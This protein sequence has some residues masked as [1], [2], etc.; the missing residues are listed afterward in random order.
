MTNIKI[1]VDG[2]GGDNAPEEIVKGAVEAVKSR[3]GFS[4]VLLG[5]AQAEES[6]KKYDYD[7]E[8]IEFV[9][10]EEVINMDDHPKEVMRKKH[11]SLVEGMMMVK[12]EQAQAFVSAGNTG[13]VLFGAQA[14][15]GSVDGARRARS[16]LAMFI[17]TLNGSTLLLDCG[18]NVDARA[19][20]LVRFARLGS[21]YYE[22]MKGVNRPKVAI[23]N[24]GSEDTK[25][26]ALVLETVPLLKE[27]ADINF[28][29][30][31][32]S[33]DIPEGKAD[34]VV[35]DAFV[36]NVILKLFEGVAT[37]M[38]KMMKDAMMTNTKTKIGAA[39]IKRE[40]KEKFKMLSS[41]EHGGA[42]LLGLSG[43]VI[44]THG[45]S[46]YIEIKN[47][48]LQCVDFVDA[49]VTG[50]MRKALQEG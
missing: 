29:G 3:D 36:G 40:L 34:I 20:D 37:S 28:V 19:S 44:K 6:L 4:V 15:V 10:C 42:P 9:P 45:N 38:M 32:E 25:G 22:N 7:K 2:M 13:A 23:V 1:A 14:Y 48:I 31:I 18:A 26:N 12:N 27:C 39:L 43:L 50:K 30:S 5:T 33:R 21:I 46:G 16:P 11:S 35:C 8:R 41:K 24:I 17:P 49:D 47:S